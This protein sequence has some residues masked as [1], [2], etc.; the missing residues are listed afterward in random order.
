MEILRLKENVVTNAVV[1]VLGEYRS[2]PTVSSN[3][4]QGVSTLI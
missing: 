2:V 1:I 3:V 4:P